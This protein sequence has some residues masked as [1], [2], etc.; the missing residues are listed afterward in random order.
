MIKIIDNFLPESKCEEIEHLLLKSY[1]FPWFLGS[2][3]TK[4]KQNRINRNPIRKEQKILFHHFI[5]SYGKSDFFNYIETTFNLNYKKCLNIRAN[6]VM[7]SGI[8]IRHSRYHTDHDNLEN[9]TT[10]I[11]Y[12]NGLNTPTIFNIGN[13]RRKLIF[14][15]KN[16][17]VIFDGNIEHAHY[18]PITKE[19]CVINFNFIN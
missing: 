18:M 10:A 15:K 4:L 12:V 7:P 16:R 19:R 5:D 11:Y 2:G 1:S 6:L 8:D 17:F 3:M 13:F 14:P 9:Y